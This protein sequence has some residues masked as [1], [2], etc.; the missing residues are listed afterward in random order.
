MKISSAYHNFFHVWYIIWWFSGLWILTPNGE[1]LDRSFGTPKG[2]HYDRYSA[3]SFAYT[4]L[5]YNCFIIIY[6]LYV[7][8]ITVTMLYLL[9]T[10]GT[11][12]MFSTSSL[13]CFFFRFFVTRITHKP[14]H[15]AWWNFAC[16][17][18]SNLDN[19]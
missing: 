7:M 1:K 14:L 13:N 5:C 9:S 12:V 18:H 11:T 10:V 17:L 3:P 8:Y 2:G 6:L 16:I 4:Y 15:L 19:L